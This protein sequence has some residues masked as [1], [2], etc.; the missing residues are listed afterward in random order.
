MFLVVLGDE[1]VHEVPQVLLTA[2]HERDRRI[3]AGL[4]QS[5]ARAD[6]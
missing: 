1:L 4:E 2:N 6:C 3:Q 5:R